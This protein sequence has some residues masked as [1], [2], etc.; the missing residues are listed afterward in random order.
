MPNPQPSGSEHHEDST[1]D[2]LGDIVRYTFADLVADLV[3]EASEQAHSDLSLPERLLRQ[4][5]QRKI[6]LAREALALP[7]DC[8]LEHGL[9][10]SETITCKHLVLR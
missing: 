2:D 1:T 10:R 9:T 5:R 8:Y 6:H 4:H 3:C 7:F